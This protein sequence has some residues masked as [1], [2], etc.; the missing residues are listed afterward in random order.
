VVT[1]EGWGPTV[2]TVE[3]QK[4]L[5]THGH[6]PTRSPQVLLLN[7]WK[8]EWSALGVQKLV[9]WAFP[10][11]VQS[12]LEQLWTLPS[13]HRS[14]AL[15]TPQVF[16]VRFQFHHAIPGK[17]KQKNKKIKGRKKQQNKNTILHQSCTG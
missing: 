13:D 7:N 1:N 3:M 8:L 14:F 11:Q 10:C 6:C 15:R 12:S 4:Q 5:G 16:S 17:Q 9:T 2:H